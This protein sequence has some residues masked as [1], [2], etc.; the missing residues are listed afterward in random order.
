MGNRT[1]EGGGNYA[2]KKEKCT[3]EEGVTWK[4][5]KDAP[6]IWIEADRVNGRK[7]R[8]MLW[9]RGTQAR[10]E[11]KWK[12]KWIWGYIYIREKWGNGKV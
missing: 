7:F 8:N 4:S 3:G 6:A 2:N 11:G 9:E 1:D 12:L 5:E 10:E